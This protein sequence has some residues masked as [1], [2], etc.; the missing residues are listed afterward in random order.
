MMGHGV[1]SLAHSVQ[2]RSAQNTCCG[3]CAG[4]LVAGSRYV[5]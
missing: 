1:V 2:H 3:M 4:A 5:F